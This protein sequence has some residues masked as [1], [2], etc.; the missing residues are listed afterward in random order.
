MGKDEAYI[1]SKIPLLCQ[2]LFEDI[3]FSVECVQ[4]LLDKVFAG[5][6]CWIKRPTFQT[7]SASESCYLIAI[8]THGVKRS[9]TIV[10]AYGSNSW[11]SICI[12]VSNAASF[13]KSLVGGRSGVPCAAYLWAT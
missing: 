13:A 2:D 7:A 9:L 8:P 1:T 5:L 10:Q 3:E 11:F 6:V 12:A 4:S